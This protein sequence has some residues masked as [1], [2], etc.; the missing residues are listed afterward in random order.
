ML[1][2]FL[3][4]RLYGG[5]WTRERPGVKPS[6]GVTPSAAGFTHETAD[7]SWVVTLSI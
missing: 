2:E 7:G 4:E 1:P 3:L 6:Y 5:S